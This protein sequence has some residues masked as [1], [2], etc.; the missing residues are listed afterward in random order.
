[1]PWQTAS[2]NGE[3]LER[4]LDVPAQRRIESRLRYLWP[5]GPYALA[6]A[7]A[8]MT[9]GLLAGC[10]QTLCGFVAVGSTVAGAV[11]VGGGRQ[12]HGRLAHGGEPAGSGMAGA[13]RAGGTVP[14]PAGRFGR[15]ICPPSAPSSESCWTRSSR[16]QRIRCPSPPC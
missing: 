9:E 14:A 11:T 10:R 7:A 15:S 6:A 2:V 4:L 5:P 1:M 8:L 16:F 3:S 13:R 12:S